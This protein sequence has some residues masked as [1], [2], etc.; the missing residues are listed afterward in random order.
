MALCAGVNFASYDDAISFSQSMMVLRMAAFFM[1]ARVANHIPQATSMCALLGFLTTDAIICF[2]IAASD[3][4]MAPSL[5]WFAAMIEGSS[6]LVLTMGLS[7]SLV[8]PHNIQA[9]MDRAW[10]LVVAPLGATILLFVTNPK[11]MMMDD[12]PLLLVVASVVL[13]LLFCLLYYDLQTAACRH[14]A[15]QSQWHQAV[16]LTLTK[17]LGWALW[18]TGACLLVLLTSSDGGGTDT[19]TTETTKVTTTT[20]TTPFIHV[21]LGWSVGGSLILFLGLR[22]FGGRPHDRLEALWAFLCWTPFVIVSVVPPSRPLLAICCYLILLSLL[23]MLEAWSNLG[24]S[25]REQQQEQDHDLGS[26]RERL[27]PL[28]NMTTMAVSTTSFSSTESSGGSET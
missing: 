3:E 23:Q 27:V 10:V 12:H 7:G 11:G 13:Q 5:W 1:I 28:T 15:S 9:T 19:P 6:D 22:L 18:T 16:L 8:I 17:L 20:T 26:E 14:V 4:S 2:A 25:A 21:L 24:L